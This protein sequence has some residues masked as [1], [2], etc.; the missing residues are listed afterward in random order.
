MVTLGA[1]AQV[2]GGRTYIVRDIFVTGNTSFSPQTIIA[3]SKLRKDQ[4]IKTW[5]R[6]ACQCCQNPMEIQFV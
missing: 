5:R 2:D 3:Y 4:E 1:S 6:K